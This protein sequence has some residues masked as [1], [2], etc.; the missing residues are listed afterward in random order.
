MTN[1]QFY[2]SFFEWEGDNTIDMDAVTFGVMLLDNTHTFDPDDEFRSDIE[3]D[4][5]SGTGYTGGGVAL[6]SVTYTRQ[7]GANGYVML[8]AAD[9]SWASLDV[10]DI[11]FVAL[12]V[13][14]GGLSSADELVC[15]YDLGQDYS[16][17][18]VPFTLRIPATGLFRKRQAA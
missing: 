4:E 11:R 17:S 15:L 3:A 10:N 5:V 2:N 18:S 1:P 16:P 14:R 6:S 9:P 12:Y 8:D 13:R 7:T